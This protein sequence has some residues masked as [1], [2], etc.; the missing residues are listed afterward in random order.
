MANRLE[1]VI[2][3]VYKKWKAGH[4]RPDT[5]HPD[6]ESWACFL[7]GRL[8]PQ[9]A[10]QMEAHLIG[11]DECAEVFAAQLE[12][13]PGLAKDM[14]AELLKRMKDLAALEIAPSIL[15]IL[16]KLKEKALEILNT[17]GDVLVG[18]EL[19]PAPILRSRKIKDFT[20]KVTI[21]K[22]FQDIRVEVKIE[23]RSGEAFDLTVFVKNKQTQ[24]VIKDLRVTLRRDDLELE[25][26]LTAS[27]SVVFEH[28]LLGK[29]MVEIS[30]I[31]AKIA[32]VLLDIKK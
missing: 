12:L 24:R 21:L 3:V 10:E 9:E 22:D 28:V 26:Y 4:A 15:E 20:D 32:S 8:A 6:E 11:C 29:Y 16:L 13:K 7:E 5:T 14:P 23:N 1:K 18:Q 27:N 25:S 30:N 17:T 2:K 31:D 19:V